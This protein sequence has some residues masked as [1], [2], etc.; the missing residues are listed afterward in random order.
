MR[1]RKMAMRKFFLGLSFVSAL[2]GAAIGVSAP[3]NAS[4]SVI[5]YSVVIQGRE[6]FGELN[7]INQTRET[8]AYEMEWVHMRQNQ[9]QPGYSNL[10]QSLTPFDITQNMVFSPRRVTVGPREAQKIRFALRLGDGQPE[11]GDYRAHLRIRQVSDPSL[12]VQSD[13]EEQRLR[14]GIGATVSYTLPVIYRVGDTTATASIGDISVGTTE[15]GRPRLTIPVSR[16]DSPYGIVGHLS[17]YHRPAGGGRETLVGE[18]GNAF[19]FPEISARTF[20]V[21][22]HNIEGGLQSG[23]IRVVLEERLKG[24]RRNPERVVADRSFPI[25][26]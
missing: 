7:L 1:K 23:T 9:D 24:T 13:G 21:P 2:A 3:A 19:L 12:S 16:N 6:R 18:V 20:R 4:I 11:N 17:V 5:P 26:H 8:K 25:G 22:L 15:S 14:L 10:D